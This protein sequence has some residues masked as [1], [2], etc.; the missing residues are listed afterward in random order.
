[1][2]HQQGDDADY[3]ENEYE[4]EEVDD[5]TDDSDDSDSDDSDSD[6][7]DSDVDDYMNNEILDILAADAR[8][9]KD[10]QGIR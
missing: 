5:Y 8:R 3:V 9:G 2:S 7:S 1:M 4:M 6:G 10:I